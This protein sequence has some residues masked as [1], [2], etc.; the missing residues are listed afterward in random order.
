MGQRGEEFLTNKRIQSKS[1]PC[2][3]TEHALNALNLS[4]S[5]V[6]LLL[7]AIEF[8]LFTLC[9]SP[10]S[11]SESFLTVK[12]AALFLPRGNGSSTPRISHRRNKHAGNMLH[13]TAETCLL[14][15]VSEST[16]LEFDLTSRHTFLF[17]PAVY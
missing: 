17:T 6:F 10:C 11:I 16:F 9:L 5:I 13:P 8:S 3:R 14:A 2:K 4:C 12:G 1:L 15:L 7:Q